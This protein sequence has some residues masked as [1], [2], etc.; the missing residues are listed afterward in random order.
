MRRT[1]RIASAVTALAA[2]MVALCAPATPGASA[3]GVQL[4]TRQLAGQRVIYSYPG[5]TPPESLL[6]LIRAGE[7]AGVIFFG[8]NISS[9]G[10]IRSV[11]QQL[12]VANQQSPVRAPLL[13]VTD[14]EGGLVRRLPGAPVLSQKQIGQASD[15]VAQAEEAGTTAGENLR[16]VGMNVN[17]APV[18]DVYR[19]PGDFLD[20]YQ[21]SYSRDP[22]VVASLG[23]AFVTAQQRITGV[24][25]AAKHFPGLGAAT[26]QQNTDAAP[27]S[28]DVPLSTLRGVD[29][30]PYPAAIGA[31]VKLVML[32]WA[33]YPALDS[34]RP[35]GLSPTV[36]QGELRGSLRFGG[37]TVSD[38]LEAGA[39]RAYG[40]TAQRSVLAAQA[41]I[42]LLLCS[43]RD[44]NQGR[45]SV[46]GLV[47]ALATGQ[48]G[49]ADFTA[50]AQRVTA[51]RTTLG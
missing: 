40:S 26:A 18:L 23:R 22:A 5:L 1:R 51:L 4:T 28:L 2:T 35:A 24:A 46:T 3:V 17:L 43:A 6:Q 49:Q 15:A 48:L 39:L 42:D 45:D 30:S 29:E 41:G 34:G 47:D 19:Q 32:S 33:T 21:R 27:V 44:V 20:Q 13:L 11:I 38:A 25:A 12:T 7:V 50:G 36:V 14:Q 31:G 16:G 10:Q 37:V 9:P 8:E